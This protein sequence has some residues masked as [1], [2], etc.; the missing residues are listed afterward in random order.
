MD[1]YLE[2]TDHSMSIV[3]GSFFIEAIENIFFKDGDH[4]PLPKS[5]EESDLNGQKLEKWRVGG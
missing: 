5:E 1:N 4:D 2:T 3:V